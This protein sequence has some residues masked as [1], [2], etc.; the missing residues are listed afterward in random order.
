ME[1]SADKIGKIVP[2]QTP[3][4][5]VVIG[6]SAGGFEAIRQCLE[7]LPRDYPGAVLIVLHVGQSSYLPEVLQSKTALEVKYPLDGET[8]KAG[9][10]Y[11]APPNRHLVVEDGLVRLS[12]GPR[13]NRHR[14][15]VD[16]LFRSAARSY[17]DRVVGI[18][19]SG[20]LD[21]GTAGLYSIKSRGGLT[22]VQDPEEALAYSMPR[23][24]LERVDPHY[25]LKAAQIGAFLKDLELDGEA[26][27]EMSPQ[28]MREQPVD[29]VCPDCG[30][31]LT[32]RVR[33]PITTYRCLVGH[34][35]SPESLDAAHQDALERAVWIAIRALEE[36]ARHYREQSTGSHELS[37][38]LRKRLE[39]SA[40]QSAQDVALLKQ[41]LS[42]L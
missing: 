14:P 13:E 34:K 7:I 12:S 19:L 15:A 10:A 20:W 26:R 38:E 9:T 18:V 39:E 23:S 1:S 42:K 6:A 11:V 3:S 29:L 8:M 27:K 32:K 24:A 40:K 5:L 31:P 21:D 16:V 25:V 35:F 2:D 36:R 37:A 41:I 17:R 4:H 22:L 30:G 28:S 33:G